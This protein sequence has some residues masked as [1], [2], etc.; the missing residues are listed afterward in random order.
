MVGNVKGRGAAVTRGFS[1]ESIER[2][3]HPLLFV[4]LSASADTESKDSA[5]GVASL[6]SR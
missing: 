3:C 6:R 2:V 5:K 1:L 4:G